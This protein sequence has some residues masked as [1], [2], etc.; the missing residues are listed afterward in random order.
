V[1]TRAIGDFFVNATSK[2]AAYEQL[3]SITKILHDPNDRNSLGNAQGAR[4]FI[5]FLRRYVVEILGEAKQSQKE[6]LSGLAL[7]CGEGDTNRTAHTAAYEMFMKRNF[8]EWVPTIP[9]IHAE[10]E[11]SATFQTERK[12]DFVNGLLNWSKISPIANRCMMCKRFQGLYYKL[13]PIPQIQQ[14]ILDDSNMSLSQIEENLS[15]MRC[16]LRST[17]TV[18]EQPRK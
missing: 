13:I 8:S 5:H 18:R 14:A 16:S 6:E 17:E 2:P 11:I 7:A 3:L 10:L 12:P 15:L 9:N 4:C 1:I